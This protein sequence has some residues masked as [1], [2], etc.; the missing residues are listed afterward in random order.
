[1]VSKEGTRFLQQWQPNWLFILLSVPNFL[2]QPRNPSSLFIFPLKSTKNES[3]S[4]RSSCKTR[5]GRR[6]SQARREE[7]VHYQRGR[8]RTV[9][10]DSRGEGGGESNEDTPSLHHHI[11]YVDSFC[12]PSHCLC[13]WLDKGTR[14]II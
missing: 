11:R 12:D 7:E 4:S 2:S 1:M 8:T 5:W 13:Q 6:R 9:L 10:A 3:L 14:S